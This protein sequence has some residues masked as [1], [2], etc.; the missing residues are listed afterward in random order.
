MNLVTS[1]GDSI[2]AEIRAADPLL[3]ANVAAALRSA[4]AASVPKSTDASCMIVGTPALDRETLDVICV[5]AGEWDLVVVV[6]GTR[7]ASMVRGA[8]ARGANGVVAADHVAILPLVLAAVARGQ[9]CVPAEDSDAVTR[10]ALSFREKQVLALVASGQTNAQIAAALYLAESTIK[11]HL[12]SAF[13][14][15][16]VS[17]RS[18]AAQLILDPDLGRGFG[19]PM[20]VATTPA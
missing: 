16:G 19:V 18:E 3:R 17:S 7:R 2:A 9:V 15:L 1:L 14:K 20:A 6:C 8:V 12:S 11:S 10:P 5:A 13:D 4:E